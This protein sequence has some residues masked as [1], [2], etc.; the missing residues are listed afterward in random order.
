MVPCR[1]RQN[2]S[3]KSTS[4]S[5]IPPSPA[6]RSGTRREVVE[7]P[8]PLGRAQQQLAPHDF[9]QLLAAEGLLE[10]GRAERPR[11]R[12]YLGTAAHEDDG[13]LRHRG[14]GLERGDEV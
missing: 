13:N 5:A 8:P 1:N 7:A 6:L 11:A 2:S 9:E 4:S 10:A 14:V 3:E 12:E